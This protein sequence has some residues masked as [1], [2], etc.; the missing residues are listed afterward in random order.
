V[1]LSP[2]PRRGVGRGLLWGLLLAVLAAVA[3]LTWWTRFGPGAVPPPPVLSEVP[4][5]TLTAQD[6]STLTRE[7]LLGAPWVA[8]L[9]FTRCVLACPV[10]SGKMAILDRELPEGV[11][12]VSITVD[13][14][15]DQ[16]AVLAA[17]ADKF[18]ASDRWLFLTG[19]RDQIAQ[20]AGEGLRLGYD[21]NPP[22]V[23]LEPGDNIYH[24]TRFVLL[25]DQARVRGYYE[26]TEGDEM[27]ALRR[28]LG[29]LD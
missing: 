2:V 27:D 4:D 6:G 19:P 24:S 22:L 8:D 10:M 3:L 28:D 15:H 9:V 17:Y 20:L 12:L 14:E 1:E 29:A 16:P 13:P 26:T 21:P 25:D 5:F 7:D 11:R 23:P 18:G